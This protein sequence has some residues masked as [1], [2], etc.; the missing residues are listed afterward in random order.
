[1]FKTN[2]LK[3]RK[4]NFGIK[5]IKEKDFHGFYFEIKG[6][7]SKNPMIFVFS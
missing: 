1:M 5:E 7:R 3:T 4:E 2:E 6:S